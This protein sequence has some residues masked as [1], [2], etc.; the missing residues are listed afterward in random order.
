MRSSLAVRRNRRWRI[1]SSHDLVVFFFK[2]SSAALLSLSSSKMLT[3]SLVI[4]YH[5]FRFFET[6]SSLRPHWLSWLWHVRSIKLLM[7]VLAMLF[8]HYAS[9]YDALDCPVFWTR[10]RVH[11]EGLLTMRG[12]LVSHQVPQM[13]KGFLTNVALMHFPVLSALSRLFKSCSSLSEDCP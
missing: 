2:R 4:F 3:F 13:S 9:S 7:T 10:R 1:E 11:L 5:S 6:F 8:Y 12:S